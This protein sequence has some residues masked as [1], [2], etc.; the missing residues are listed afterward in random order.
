MEL[1][2]NDIAFLVKRIRWAEGTL[3]EKDF[4]FR[5]IMQAEAAIIIL[6]LAGWVWDREKQQ[7]FKRTQREKREY[8]NATTTN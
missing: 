2:D 8:F 7:P 6:N 4:G 3:N 1:S 5:P